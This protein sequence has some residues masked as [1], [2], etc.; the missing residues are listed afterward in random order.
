MMKL[1]KSATLIV[2]T[3]QNADHI[4]ISSDL[5]NDLSAIDDVVLQKIISWKNIV[6]HKR[7]VLPSPSPK[8]ILI[9]ILCLILNK[10]IF[11]GIH[12]IEG[13]EQKDKKK[14]HV[15]NYVVTKLAT[16]VIVYSEFSKK[17]LQALFR[18]NGS[19]FTYY[20]IAAELT[21]SPSLKGSIDYKADILY[22]GRANEY[23][24]R[25]NLEN[26]VKS[27]PTKK[28][29]LMGAGLPERLSQ[30]EN[31][32]LL[33]R[34]FT[35]F[36]LHQA[37]KFRPTIIFPYKSA[38]QSGGI[39]LAISYC[40]NVVFFNVGGLSDQLR[41]YPSTSVLPTDLMAFCEALQLINMK[42]ES[43]DR[44]KWIDEI[45]F[46]NRKNLEELIGSA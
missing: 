23:S 37:L 36:E 20:F 34:R 18:I 28:F 15:Y 40:C 44:G 10:K 26:I 5:Y 4:R 7:I 6:S 39:P 17:Q 27:L 13:H 9:L 46:E 30:Y 12:D 8:N 24:G 41:N 25:D 3:N 45:K 21:Q 14:V 42:V 11:I 38:T 32:T 16:G 31:V 19:I 22:F 2:N 1:S 35:D 33:S 29:L 43:R